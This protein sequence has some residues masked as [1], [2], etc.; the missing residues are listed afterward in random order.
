MSQERVCLAWIA[1]A[2]ALIDTASES[3]NRGGSAGAGSSESHRRD[4]RRIMTGLR[5]PQHVGV[6]QTRRKLHRWRLG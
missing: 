2:T 6:P 3:A 1:G 4:F 5:P